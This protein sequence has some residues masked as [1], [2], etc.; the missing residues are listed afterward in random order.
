ME[1]RHHTKYGGYFYLVPKALNA[2]IPWRARECSRAVTVHLEG[3][4][5]EIVAS[6][7]TFSSIR[8]LS[9]WVCLRFLI[10][11]GLLGGLLLP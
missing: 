2:P 10:P 4:F 7:R 11:A 8:H 9:I 6:E 5:E 1:L 3:T